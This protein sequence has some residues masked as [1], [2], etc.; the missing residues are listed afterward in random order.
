M[1]RRTIEEIDTELRAAVKKRDKYE[2]EYVS[3]NP[4]PPLTRQEY[5]ELYNDAKNEVIRLG[6]EKAILTKDGQN[7]EQR[8]ALGI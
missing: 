6:K 2:Q 7:S 1:S 3:A 4:A 8:L 5:K